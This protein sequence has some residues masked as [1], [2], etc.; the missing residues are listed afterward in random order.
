MLCEFKPDQIPA[1]EGDGHEVL[2]Q[3]K[4]VLALDSSWGKERG[5]L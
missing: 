1:Q 2:S 5:F 4:E 3:V